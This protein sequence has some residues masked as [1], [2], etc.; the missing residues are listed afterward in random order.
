MKQ[1][2]V[3]AFTHKVFAGN[4]AAVCVMDGWALPFWKHTLYLLDGEALRHRK[5]PHG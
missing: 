4:S 1:Y 3:D 5:I 2:A